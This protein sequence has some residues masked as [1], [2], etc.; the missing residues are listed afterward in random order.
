M[1]RMK[2]IILLSLVVLLLTGNRAAMAQIDIWDGTASDQSWYNESGTSFD[3]STAAAL[4]GFR[5]LVNGGKNFNGKTVRLTINIDLGSYTWAPIAPANGQFQGVFDGDWHIIRNLVVNGGT[6]GFFGYIGKAG[7]KEGEGKVLN[8]GLINADITVTGGLG[9]GFAAQLSPGSV[10]ENCYVSGGTVRG[11][12]GTGVGGFVGFAN[13]KRV[14]NCYTSCNV[15]VTGVAPAGGFAGTANSTNSISNCY[16][17][18][19]VTGKEG[20]TG[21][22]AGNGGNNCSNSYSSGFVSVTGKGVVGAFAG[23][24]KVPA[25]CYYDSQ[26]VT[27]SG[28]G[29]PKKRTELFAQ[30]ISDAF[31]LKNGMYPQLKVFAEGGVATP[32]CKLASEFSVL[33]LNFKGEET[34]GGVMNDFVLQ[35]KLGG[36]SIL[37][38]AQPA[39]YTDGGNFI[40]GDEDIAVELSALSGDYSKK[41]RF[42]NGL[43][44]LDKIGSW[45]ELKQWAE[46]YGKSSRY[47]ATGTYTLTGDIKIP[48]GEWTSFANFQGTMDGAGHAIE[49]LE[50]PFFAGLGTKACVKNLHLKNVNIV[51]PDNIS[52]G[53]LVTK[54]DQA[55]VKIMGCSVS[56]KIIKQAMENHAGGLIGEITGNTL[57]HGSYSACEVMGFVTAGTA[58]KGLIGG[59]VGK[60]S[61]QAAKISNCYATGDVGGAYNTGGF[62]GELTTGTIENCYTIGRVGYL[63][64]NFVGGFAGAMGSGTTATIKG[65]YVSAVL[66]DKPANVFGF[67]GR[68]NT[69]GT[70]IDCFFDATVC[71]KTDPK[72]TSRTTAELCAAGMVGSGAGILSDTAFVVTPGEYAQL[73]VLKES[74]YPGHQ[75]S[76]LFSVQVLNIG[77]NTKMN[78]LDKPFSLPSSINGMEVTWASDPDGYI[79]DGIYTPIRK[80]PVKLSVVSGQNPDISKIYYVQ[81]NGEVPTEIYTVRD[82][83]DFVSDVNLAGGLQGKTFTLHN[84]LDLSGEKEIWTSI[85][86][87]DKPFDAIFDGKGHVISGLTAP[88][89]GWL[90]TNA[91]I[92]DVRLQNVNID[93]E[94]LHVGALVGE[95]IKVAGVVISGCSSSGQIMQRSATG[96]HSAGGLVGVISQNVQMSG[97]YS[98]CRME[99]IDKSSGVTGGLVGQ[100]KAAGAEI[101]NCF[102]MGS[103]T[104]GYNAGGLVGQSNA[105][106]ITACYATGPVMDAG[107]HTGGLVGANNGATV[108]NCYAAGRV[109]GSSKVGGL[110]AKYD[111]S[112]VNCFFDRQNSGQEL[113]YDPTASGKNTG[114]TP[115]SVTELCV[116]ESVGVSGLPVA[117]FVATPGQ[118]YPQLIIFAE[119]AAEIGRLTSQVSTVPLMID[120]ADNS[121]ALTKEI[122]LMQSLAGNPLKWQTDQPDFVKGDKYVPIG[123]DEVVLS[124]SLNSAITRE[125]SLKNNVEV[126]LT[127]TIS[128]VLELKALRDSVNAGKDTFEEYF[129]VADIDMGG[130]PFGTAIGTEANPFHV[131]FEGNGHTIS[132]LASMEGLF[133]YVKG[134]DGTPAEIKNLRLE[135]VRINGNIAGG[136]GALVK[137]AGDY[138]RMIHCSVSGNVMGQITTGTT[139]VGGLAGMLNGTGIEI[140]GCYSSCRVTHE[141]GDG[142]CG[143]LV[144][145]TAGDGFS[146]RNSFSSGSVITSGNAEAGGLIGGNEGTGELT[147]CY[148]SG[149]VMALKT[150]NCGGFIGSNTGI[151]T[152]EKCFYDVQGTS[153]NV[154]ISGEDVLEGVTGKMTSELCGAA[155]VGGE[156]LS[157]QAFVAREGFYPQLTCFADSL[158]DQVASALAALPLMLEALDSTMSVAELFNLPAKI[159]EISIVW[160]TDKQGYISGNQFVPTGL[161]T[162]VL[163]ATVGKAAKSY[164]LVNNVVPVRNQITSKEDLAA[165]TARWGSRE[166]PVNEH[167][168]LM[169]DID[170][171]GVTW[172]AIGGTKPFTG[173]FD[174]LGHTVTG[175]TDGLFAEVGGNGGEVEIKNVRLKASV[176]VS[177]TVGGFVGGLVY[178]NLPGSLLRLE[179]CSVEGKVTAVGTAGGLVGELNGG[180]IQNSYTSCTVL[181]RGDVVGGLAGHVASG[182]IVNCYAVGPVT[183]AAG[184]TGGFIGKNGGTVSGCFAAGSVFADPGNATA[185]AFIGLSSVAAADVTNCYTDQ[186]GSGLFQ[187]IGSGV[188]G[189]TTKTTMEMCAAALVGPDGLPADAFTIPTGFIYPQLNVFAGQ[190]AD[191]NCS[192]IS[193]LPLMLNSDNNSS[194]VGDTLLLPTVI[195]DN[196]K[197][198]WNVVNGNFVGGKFIPSG[199]EVVTLT[200][201]YEGCRKQFRLKSNGTMKEIATLADLE[202]LRDSINAGGTKNWPRDGKYLMTA[203]IDLSAANWI[204]IGAVNHTDS[205]FNGVFDGGGFAITGLK[206]Y[207]SKA[208]LFGYLGANL[209]NVEVKN[210]YLRNVDIDASIAVPM[211]ALAIQ[212]RPRITSVKISN[213]YVS[214]QIVNQDTARSGNAHVGGLIGYVAEQME[215][216]NCYSSCLVKNAGVS[217]GGLIG[218][219]N[220]DKSMVQSCYVTGMVIGGD[221]T[222]GLIGVNTGGI[223][224]CY[225]AGGVIGKG[226]TGALVGDCL[227]EAGKIVNNFFD[228][229]GTGLLKGFGGMKTG[230]VATSKRTGEMCAVGMVGGAALP[231]DAFITQTGYYPQLAAFAGSADQKV[232]TNSAI[233]ALPLLLKGKTEKVTALRNDFD[234]QTQIVANGS[235]VQLD[236]TSDKT[237]FVDGYNFKTIL[238]DTVWISVKPQEVGFDQKVFRLITVDALGVDYVQETLPDVDSTMKTTCQYKLKGSDSWSGIDNLLKAGKVSV[239]SLILPDQDTTYL[240]K[241]AGFPE[242]S[243][244]IPSRPKISFLPLAE[245]SINY[246][247]TFK[248]AATSTLADVPVRFYTKDADTLSIV[249]DS[250]VT[251]R[252]GNARIFALQPA[253]IRS[254]RSDTSGIQVLRISRLPLDITLEGL[255]TKKVYDKTDTLGQ[256]IKAVVLNNKVGSDD[257]N[258]TVIGAYEDV[259][260]GTDKNIVMYYELNGKDTAK[261]IMPLKEVIKGEIERAVPVI[262][263]KTDTVEGKIMVA[264]GKPVL[265]KATARGVGREVLT[266]SI[267]F[268][269]SSGSEPV[270]VGEYTVSARIDEQDYYGESILPLIIYDK[271]PVKVTVL[272]DKVVYTGGSRNVRYVTEPEGIE[273]LLVFTQNGERVV[274]ENVGVY[275]VEAIASPVEFYVGSGAGTLTIEKADQI[276]NFPSLGLL[277]LQDRSMEV[278]AEASSGLP[279]SL[280]SGDSTIVS[281]SGYVLNLHKIGFV[282]VT[283]LQEGNENWNAA[284]K[285]QIIRIAYEGNDPNK[286]PE[287]K[288]VNVAIG[289]GRPVYLEAIDRSF[290]DEHTTTL[291]VFNRMGKE[292][293]KS[294]KGGYGFDYDLSTLPVG[295]Y[296]YV[297]TYSVSGKPQVKKSFVEVVK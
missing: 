241:E 292:V 111:G 200:A 211:G 43:P 271:T 205:V 83:K 139:A 272:S 138:T 54:I 185:G 229:Q 243:M 89:F 86:I 147:G 143:G 286:V 109:R 55:G 95:E 59:F 100:L 116:G 264:V 280:I 149:T 261:Y 244:F 153:V 81:N 257:V 236:W 12:E 136:I 132:G 174:G 122:A 242:T 63:T 20:P 207:G 197:V 45:E 231:P 64:Q 48:A 28:E 5:D 56:G 69:V 196:Q 68:Q 78:A 184:N 142:Q 9:G 202:T 199:H 166:F 101:K 212:T 150:V 281:I 169:A 39:E 293:Y 170:M 90:A 230:T 239:T 29:I 99:T 47:P 120:A 248:L 92:K 1:K 175:L 251:K 84:D 40:H 102:A 198:K 295:T 27:A 173:S 67:L 14:S 270:E 253:G 203:D 32:A 10:C 38:K 279:V 93:T 167:Y 297:M 155:M 172:K 98:S 189:V 106:K 183:G 221:A 235:P 13:G 268:L 284:Q 218:K 46:N 82:L 216:T 171:T 262:T 140:E 125:F 290:V 119:S 177:G 118:L 217:T 277:K 263:W 104:G 213:C 58:S 3:I 51:F 15:V 25:T 152:M 36:E 227:A 80:I 209:G 220:Q 79:A 219:T 162:V 276:I 156:N 148:A 179:N 85:G 88:L 154:G 252:P 161:D 245:T 163:T 186:Q 267:Q 115:L 65:C 44:P 176:V 37:W 285:S 76:S 105:G 112:A 19:V 114:I 265:L 127:G 288:M 159:G 107:Q 41:F 137:N 258:L 250:I 164:T 238:L 108:T 158:N 73:K 201:T 62:I 21:G 31:L 187:P 249:T 126:V 282:E 260:A 135:G 274:P 278:T 232:V 110:F 237:G 182:S 57:V 165:M 269:F 77:E 180:S 103:V 291:V 24:G 70:L 190:P 192:A 71:G 195:G 134:V 6:G 208:G 50:V 96:G 23:A 52:C 275:D 144:G 240:F 206:A 215:M 121:G 234:L 35:Q 266:D 117:D 42:M 133:G 181:S 18:G 151:L 75:Y 204:P 225:V 146:V 16:A 226:K 214:G 157:E 129:L 33:P 233:S 26:A 128:H 289:D 113:G 8:L 188:G 256:R 255:V 259:H 168:Q 91:R 4:A 74:T 17:T 131:K 61:N 273:C 210:V 97:C 124:V 145:Y 66:A 294:A 287:L 228:L 222:G 49:G 191:R 72:V 22:F 141:A 2:I 34:A 30:F 283:A 7:G 224:D 223:Q 160:S 246:G 53:A 123:F 94:A 60:I 193:G 130:L 178:R 254:F 247:S 296:Y 87:V 194:A 11:T